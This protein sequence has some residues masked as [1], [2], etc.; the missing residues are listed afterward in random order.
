MDCKLVMRILRKH[1][2]SLKAYNMV[3]TYF[4]LHYFNLACVMQEM[5][6]VAA[7]S[8]SSTRRDVVSYLEEAVS[9]YNLSCK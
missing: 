7:Y 4:V 3:S 8:I 1:H 2:V 5:C 9:V 6:A